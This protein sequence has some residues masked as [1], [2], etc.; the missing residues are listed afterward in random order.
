LRQANGKTDFATALS[1][2]HALAVRYL[3]C[4]TVYGHDIH[5]IRQTEV[6]LTTS[7]FFCFL[8]PYCR[9]QGYRLQ[10][11]YFEYRRIARRSFLQKSNV[12]QKSDSPIYCRPSLTVVISSHLSP[13]DLREAE[14][15]LDAGE[16]LR[17][18]TFKKEKRLAG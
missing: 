3:F 1:A 13:E 4:C 10:S 11:A 9:D 12:M 18:A 17:S 16:Q 15:V 14:N 5:G 6:F 7:A 2:G 8:Q